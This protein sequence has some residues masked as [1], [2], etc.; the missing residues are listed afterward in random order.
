V[1]KGR[2]E[3]ETANK[4]QKKAGKKYLMILLAL[5][6]IAMIFVLI[7]RGRIRDQKKDK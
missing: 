2:L 3:L 5:V 7:I 4:Y 6:V 1:E